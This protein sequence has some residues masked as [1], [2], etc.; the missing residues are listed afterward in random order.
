[1]RG[2]WGVESEGTAAGVVNAEAGRVKVAAVRAGAGVGTGEEAG[3]GTG[4]PK[5]SPADAANVRAG[6]AAGLPN[7]VENV[8]AGAGA[9]GLL[10]GVVDMGAGAENPKAPVGGGGPWAAGKCPAGGGGP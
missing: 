4:A 8:G 6:A 5:L 7:G 10:K 9:A 3:A 1:M 2:C